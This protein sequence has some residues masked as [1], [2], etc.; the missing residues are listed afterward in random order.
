MPSEEGINTV[1]IIPSKKT[2]AM[3]VKDLIR[4]VLDFLPLL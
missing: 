4:R 3:A 2:A 1:M